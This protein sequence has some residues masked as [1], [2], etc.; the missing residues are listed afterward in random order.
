[1]SLKAALEVLGFGPCY[2]M[3]ELLQHVDHAT[4]WN[5]AAAGDLAALGV[6]LAD[7]RSTV[8][9]PGCAF[10]EE[11]IALHPTAKVVLSVRPAQSWYAS[12]KETVGAVLAAGQAEDP[13]SVPPEFRP[14]TTMRDRVV[15]DR[16]FGAHF[17]VD[18]SEDVLA[19]YERHTAAVRSTVPADR[20]L[21]FDV[22]QGWEPLCEFLEVSVPA[23]PF[24]FV[25]D[26]ARFRE[27]FGLDQ[28]ERRLS[29]EGVQAFQDRFA[30]D[31]TSTPP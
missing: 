1:M 3:Y 5:A 10:W 18:A 17:D 22:A 2:H 16:S 9:W 11:L 4:S 13:E 8:D 28:Q 6:P 25:N 20:L 15:R 14:V 21:E 7:Y 23:A 19:A 29:D 26:R 27:L 31:A 12:F 30:G 24:P